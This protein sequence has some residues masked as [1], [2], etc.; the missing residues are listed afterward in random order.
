MRY[1]EMRAHVRAHFN[2]MLAAFREKRA[3]DGLPEGMALSAL[4]TAQWLD[5][6]DPEDFATLSREIDDTGLLR[7]FCEAR[8]ISPVPE[9][10]ERELLL[11]ELQKGYAEYG[12]RALAHVMEFDTL[13]LDEVNSVPTK[14]ARVRI[15][16][17]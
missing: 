15:Y 11:A 14:T 5:D 16:N 6:A 9:G 4:R 13:K 2:Q 7:A 12:S 17:Q 1:D 8:G 10:R 3:E